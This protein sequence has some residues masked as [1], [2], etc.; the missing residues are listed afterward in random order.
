[1]RAGRRIRE[2]HRNHNN[3]RKPRKKANIRESFRPLNLPKSLKCETVVHL[4]SRKGSP[5][6][7]PRKC[8]KRPFLRRGIG[9]PGTDAKTLEKAS[10]RLPEAPNGCRRPPE[11]YKKLIKTLNLSKS[12]EMRDC[13]KFDL[14]EEVPTTKAKKMLKPVISMKGN[15]ASWHRCQN[16]SKGFPEAPG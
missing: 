12:S 2:P 1:M 5:P 14:P 15:R 8:S 11:S 6:Q 9:P 13:R 7:K 3:S 16:L 4:T 10:R